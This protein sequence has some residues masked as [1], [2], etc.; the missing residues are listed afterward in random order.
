MKSRRTIERF[1]ELRA[2]RKSY[3]EIVKKTGIS[4]PTLIKWG[5]IYKDEIEKVKLALATNLTANIVYRNSVL[6]NNIAENLKRAA[7]NKTVS[8]EIKE[9]FINKS[10]KKLEDIF[11]VKI[12]NINISFNGDGDVVGVNISCE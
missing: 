6:I 10:H 8:E 1:I 11:K 5:K 9:K 7:E 4:K 2:L 3:D 12:K